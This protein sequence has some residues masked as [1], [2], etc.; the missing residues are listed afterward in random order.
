MGALKSNQDNVP[1]PLSKSEVPISTSGIPAM[2]TGRRGVPLSVPL[3]FLLTGAC[4]A[5]LFGILLPWIAPDAIQ[6]PGFPHVLALVHIATLGWLTMTIMGA[7]LQLAPVIVVAPLRAARFIR[8]Q[9]PVYVS[10]VVLLLSGFWWMLPWLMAV[11]GIVV[12]LA[13]AHYVVVLGATLAHATARPLTVRFLV[14]SLIYLCIVVSLGLTAAFNFQ[15]GFLGAAFN[16]LLLTHITLGILGWLSSTLIGVSYTLGRM[17]ALAHGH[18]DRLGRLI[19]VLLNASIIGLALGFIFSWFP[20]ILAGEG[21]L[22][23]TAW[24]FAYDFTCILRARR[25]KGLDVTQYH[26]MA[27]AGYFTLL[28]PFGIVTALLGRWQPAVLAALGLAALVGWLGQSM[29]GYL[30]KIVPFLIWHARYGP[31]VG[32]EHVPLMRELVHERW[33]WASFWLINVGLVGAIL[34]A[35]LMW[36]WSLQIASGLLGA[37]LVLAAGNVA[38]VVRH[39]DRRYPAVHA[40]Q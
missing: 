17:F 34:S 38:G 20:M 11:G 15:F 12:V 22:L 31:L 5:A 32:R 35:L 19:F 27:A 13:V 14:G 40:Q 30:Y 25:R 28:I 4:A 23:A 6:S 33:A 2:M 24:L 8:W 26:S 3:P 21:M 18:S 9:Y 29:I 36:V 16:Q 37:G 7:S 10:G 1:F 39:L